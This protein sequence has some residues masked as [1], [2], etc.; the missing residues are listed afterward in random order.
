MSATVANAIDMSTET[1]KLVEYFQRFF[2]IKNKI[3]QNF[4]ERKEKINRLLSTVQYP[5][6]ALLKR[7]FDEKLGRGHTLSETDWESLRSCISDR[8]SGESLIHG[9]SHLSLPTSIYYEYKQVIFH[10]VFQKTEEFTLTPLLRQTPKI[11]ISVDQM[12]TY[13]SDMDER[14]WVIVQLTFILS[15]LEEEYQSIIHIHKQQDEQHQRE[16]ELFMSTSSDKE[17]ESN[18]MALLSLP[19][20][21]SHFPEHVLASIK[22]MF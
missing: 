21:E 8:F 19:E 4:D 3:D 14:T 16:I 6:I 10:C 5:I 20:V 11:P 17:F 18:I 2:E 15:P 1:L 22:D 9:H 13:Y 7:R 12:R